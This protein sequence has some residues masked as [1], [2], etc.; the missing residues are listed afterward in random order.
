MNQICEKFLQCDPASILTRNS[1]GLRRT[2]IVYFVQVIYFYLRINA[3]KKGEINMY[4]LKNFFKE[5]FG[6]KEY[7]E[8][9]KSRNKM[10]R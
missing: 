7:E 1:E 3:Y 4:S 2:E 8:Y 10:F 6:E 5:F 9:N